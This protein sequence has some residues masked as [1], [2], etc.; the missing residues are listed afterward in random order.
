M[1]AR[2]ETHPILARAR[3][4]GLFSV[5]SRT[6]AVN[7]MRMPFRRTARRR[8]ALVALAATAAALLGALPARAYVPSLDEIYHLVAAHP[9]PLQR[10]MLETRTYVFDPLHRVDPVGANANPDAVAPEL[11]TREYRQ[12]IYWIRNSFLGIE[13]YAAD[14]TLLHFYLNEGFLPVQGNL[15]AGRSFSEADVVHPFLAFVAADPARWRQAVTFWGLNPKRVEIAR[16]DKGEVYYRLAEDEQKA[17]WLDPELLRP[18][19]LQTRLDG[20]D[21]GGRTL[22]I[23]FREFMFIGSSDN[24]AENF[25]FPRTVDFL[26]DGRLFKQIV[27]LH[28]ES[29]PSVQGFPITKL[30]TLAAKVQTPQPVSLNPQPAGKP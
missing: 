18:I 17:L 25:Y 1:P 23:E 19:K 12:K 30:R 21:Q 4:D 26:L 14:G 15:T 7:R 22:T 28:F 24:D 11:P 27:V 16:G 13:T 3:P 2:P 6:P 10:A 8:T 5:F 29:D 9:A 20:G